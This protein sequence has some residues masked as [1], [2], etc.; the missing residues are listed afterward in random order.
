L[1]GD[2]TYVEGAG[3]SLTEDYVTT[4]DYVTGVGDLSKLLRVAPGEGATNI[5]DEI[6][7]INERIAWQ[8][9]KE[10]NQA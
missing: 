6:N 7:Y 4:S 1:S 8:D 3:L 10:S 9:M 2:F 5:V